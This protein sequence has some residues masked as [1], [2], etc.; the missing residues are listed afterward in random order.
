MKPVAGME[1]WPNP[2]MAS[3]RRKTPLEYRRTLRALSQL[4]S[5]SSSSSSKDDEKGQKMTG[6][7]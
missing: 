3:E 6:K 2:P 4:R 5:F 1:A 7:S